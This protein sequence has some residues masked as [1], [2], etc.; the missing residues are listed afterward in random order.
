VGVIRLLNINFSPIEGVFTVTPSAVQG[1]VDT[2][3]LT[4]TDA[5]DLVSEVSYY[6]YLYLDGTLMDEDIQKRRN[7]ENGYL[8]LSDSPPG[9]YTIR[10]PL[11][12]TVMFLCMPT[13]T[14]GAA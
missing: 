8:I 9:E 3:T 1:I 5:V 11:V 6:I 4:F 7:Y 2:I 10:A 14:G 12:P 13:D